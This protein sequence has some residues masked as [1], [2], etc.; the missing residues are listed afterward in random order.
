VYQHPRC[1]YVD[2]LRSRDVTDITES[3]RRRNNEVIRLELCSVL[4]FW[5]LWLGELG[6]PTM[7]PKFF[8]RLPVMTFGIL[9][10]AVVVGQP[11]SVTAEESYPWCTQGDTLQ[12]YYMTREQCEEAVDYHGFC[13]ANSNVPT[14]NNE[15]PQPRLVRPIQ[16]PHYRRR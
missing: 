11:V 13:V 14:L 15:G 7:S 2:D 1:K 5:P 4:D 12:C 16:S 8:V 6:L 10:V 9:G 3:A